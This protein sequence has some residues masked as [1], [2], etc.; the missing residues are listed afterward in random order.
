M[1]LYVIC[2]F[3]GNKLKQLSYQHLKRHGITPREYKELFPNSKLMA[4]DVLKKISNISKGHKMSIESRNK[5]SV[6][7]KGENNPFYGKHHTE[8]FRKRLRQIRKKD[9]T[10]R[11]PEVRKKIS[12]ALKDK[13]KSE[14]HRKNLSKA[15]IRYYKTHDVWNKGK[16]FLVGERNPMYEKHHAEETK[17]KIRNS[18]YH[19]N[20]SGENNPRWEGGIS[21]EPYGPEFNDK[22]KEQ[23]RKRDDYICQ[24]CGAHQ[25]KF[26]RALD[27]HHIDYDKK[28][29]EPE[30]LISLCYTCNPMVNTKRRFWMT[31]FMGLLL[32]KFYPTSTRT[33]QTG[34]LL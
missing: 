8:E 13:P 33:G 19:K 32:K 10:S 31:Y 28:N 11:R 20:L 2:K 22:L 26:K 23:I 16:P 34:L 21:F 17:E 25:S 30:N 3:C 24:L 9:P 12:L 27:V 29:N 1:E 5:L 18:E 7:R 14:E 6:I 15:K 4:E